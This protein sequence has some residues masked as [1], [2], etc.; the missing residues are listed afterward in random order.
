MDKPWRFEC[1]NEK[2]FLAEA[3]TGDI[4]LFRGNEKAHKINRMLTWSRYDHVAFVIR[5]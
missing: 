2:K 4:L 5:L 3:E 1:I